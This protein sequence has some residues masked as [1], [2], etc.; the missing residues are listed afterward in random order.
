[1][2]VSKDNIIVIDDFLTQDE[3]ASALKAVRSN[4]LERWK[5]NS[6]LMIVPHKCLD[7]FTWVVGSAHKVSEVI[8]EKF[9]VEKKIYCVE[10]QI[11]RWDLGKDLDLHDDTYDAKFTKYSSVIY[12]TSDYEG[13]EI[14]FPEF[15]L[16]IK[17][18]AG[19]LLL[20]P[21][22]GYWH[23]VNPVTSGDRSTIVAFYTDIDPEFWVSGG[24][25]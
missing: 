21:A 6:S 22:G 24:G 20:F 23:K 9:S 16:S 18:K 8:A 19:Q 2:E 7:A 1:M 14:E 17:P 15:G 11:G 12:L 13:G 3:V 25:E 10:G 4:K 5:E